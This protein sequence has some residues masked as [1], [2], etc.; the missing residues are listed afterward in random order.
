MTTFIDRVTLYAS[1][2]KGGDGCVSVKREKF[3]P[4][5]G[6]D[7]GN[8]GRGGDIILIVDPS[9]TTLLDFHHSPHRKATS[10]SQGYG[11]RKD[12]T[13]GE[14]LILPVP[15][16]TVVFDAKG[17][18]LADLI[19]TGTTFLAAQG[20]HGGLGNL[21]LSSSKRRAP[22][23]ALLG[24]PGE[25]RTLYLELKSVADIALVGYPSAGKSSLIAAISA[26]R[27]K[28]ADYPFTTLVPNL[29]VVQAGETRFTVADVP[30]LI[31]GASQGK[32]LGL[33][34]LRHV[35]RCVALVHVLDCGTLETDRDP[36][37]DLEII[38][39]ELAIYGG[40]EDRVRIVALNKID[41]PDGRAMA[42]MVAQTLRDKGYEVYPVSAA[43]R[44]G[45]QELLYAM[46]R[47]VQKERAAAVTE[48]RT[49]IILRPTAV[50]DSGFT[51]QANADG[52]FSVRGQKVVRWV[53]QTNFK[54]AEAIGYLADRLAQLGVEK[55][56]FKKGAVAG[57]EVR[58]GSGDNEVV[59]EWEPTIEAG[60]EQLAGHLHRRGEDSRLEGA[61][62]VEE[63]VVDQL[64]DDEI[65]Q[66]WEYN[67][68][69]PK[70][71]RLIEPTP[72]EDK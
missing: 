42:D 59:F 30:G 5:G 51:V 61:W 27:P 54:N 17:N 3:K 33:E 64:S 8:G 6:P 50:D 55:E 46:A 58:I 1:A 47:L 24:E 22:G 53:R 14:D 39:A 9:V 41:L 38:E 62:V 45:L 49:R 13:Y 18:Q 67:V 69:D 68:E 72:S 48:E 11:D 71:P 60:A 44:E 40:L 29:G 36:V 31:P 65:A 34:F 12:G 70:T 37:S 16:G 2:G 10:G 57:S 23:F 4:L 26:A 32:G 15:N 28:I 66:Q 20:G 56:L 19:G 63:K 21:A 35:E 52:S 25:E 43:S 7:G